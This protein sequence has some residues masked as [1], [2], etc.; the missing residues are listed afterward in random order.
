MLLFHGHVQYTNLRMNYK[1]KINK[2]MCKHILAMTF[3]RLNTVHISVFCGN[4][5]CL[6]LIKILCASLVQQLRV[7]TSLLSWVGSCHQPFDDVTSS[8]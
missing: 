7:W 3:I 5:A 1:L 2:T 6:S 4:N 8:I